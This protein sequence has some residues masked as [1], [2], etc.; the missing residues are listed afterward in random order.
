LR[1][2]RFVLLD[3]TLHFSKQSFDQRGLRFHLRL[4][5][6]IFGR[7]MGEHISI[8]NLGIGLILDPEIGIFDG[9]AV[10]GVAVEAF[11]GDGRGRCHGNFLKTLGVTAHPKGMKRSFGL[12]ELPPIKLSII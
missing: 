5:I 8:L 12:T 4:K 2:R 11:L 3:P 1:H 7:Q 6:R 10:R 9:D